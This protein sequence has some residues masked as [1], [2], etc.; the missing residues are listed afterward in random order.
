MPRANYKLSFRYFGPFQILEKIGTVAYRLH[1]P[2][3][4]SIHPVFHV[5]QLK[6][7]VGIDT[8]VSSS[9]PPTST[10]FQVLEQILQRRTVSHNNQVIPQVLVKWSYWPSSLSTWDNE[11]SLRQSF[12]AA[13]AWGQAGFDGRGN[14]MND[15]AEDAVQ[16]EAD[17]EDGAGRPSRNHKPNMKYFGPV[18]RPK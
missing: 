11:A 9:L 6:H 5:S 1:L 3:S 10:Q 16:P 17:K 4:S 15:D 7:A 18:W 2:P 14:V 8:Q 13:L 12:P